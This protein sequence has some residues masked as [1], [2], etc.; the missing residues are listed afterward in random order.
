[1]LKCISISDIHL[2]INRI[3][4]DSIPA[5]LRTYLYPHLT[6]DLDILFI[7][8]DFFDGDIS[9]SSQVSHE[10][11]LVISELVH[12]AI[13]NDFLI[14][15]VQGTFS[16][17]KH[18]LQC[19]T[20]SKPV[21]NRHNEEVVKVFNTI[22][23]EFIKSLNTSIMYIPDDL[24]TKD[25]IGAIRACLDNN[26]VTQVDIM[27]HHGYFTHLL[28]R[29]MPHTPSNTLDETVVA[30]L[31]KGIVLNGHIHSSSVH[32][33][34]V[35]NGSFDRLAHGEEESKGFFV[36]KLYRSNNKVE[37][38]FIRNK[39]ATI[40]HTVNLIYFKDDIVSALQKFK[41]ELHIAGEDA[42]GDIFF[43]R[44]F[45][46]NLNIR[47]GAIE[48]AIN[49]FPNVKMEIK[50]TR[51]VAVDKAI[52]DLHR[53]SGL[54]VITDSNLPSRV[55][56]YTKKSKPTLDINYIKDKLNGRY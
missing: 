15:V 33:K 10:S 54:P 1:M 16:H 44:V 41:E 17:D 35:N 55:L 46:D 52:S 14:R 7:V 26:S 25:A 56:D 37:L 21:Y 20:T 31:V 45:S 4:A 2:G 36:F 42:D 50:K 5:R 9:M 49:T 13:Q 30:K 39:K 28:P 51:S 29:G 12:L 19:F 34:V 43:I 24:A 27:L 3:P 8:G 23:I 38:K 40:R 48:Y 22:D 32:K 18:Q 6:K 47:Q 53:L 11:L